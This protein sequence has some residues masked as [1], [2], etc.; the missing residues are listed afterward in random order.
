MN[1]M[2]RK[3]LS[4]TNKITGLNNYLL[5]LL[6]CWGLLAAPA[7]AAQESWWFG[8]KT[9]ISGDQ[10]DSETFRKYHASF[11][12]PLPWQWRFAANWSAS[13]RLNFGLGVLRAEGESA[14]IGAVGPGVVL[15][16]TGWSPVL[17]LGLSPTYIARD[18]FGSTDLGGQFHFTSQIGFYIPMTDRLAI[19][20][21]FEHISNAS[22]ETV[23]PGLNLHLVGLSW[24]WR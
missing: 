1:K 19:G 20:Y 11:S 17:A 24:R 6:T 23:N 8:L 18:K 2:E 16:R 12:Y 14:F 21:T 7:T 10:V 15:Q 5:C 4:N 9:T 13:A 3:T 22:I